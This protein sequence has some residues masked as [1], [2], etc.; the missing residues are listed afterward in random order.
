M[1]YLFTHCF[2]ENICKWFNLLLFTSLQI[3]NTLLREQ[4]PQNNKISSDCVAH[5]LNLSGKNFEKCR[6]TILIFCSLFLLSSLWNQCLI[7]RDKIN[8]YA[9]FQLKCQRRQIFHGCKSIYNITF[10][11]C[12][13]V[14]MLLCIVLWSFFFL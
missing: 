1:L 12:L 3:E 8:F 11:I 2:V 10:S 14:S 7:E 6:K 4:N 9:S 5:L 13:D